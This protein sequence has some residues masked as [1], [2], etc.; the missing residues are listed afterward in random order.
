MS[1][2]LYRPTY[3]IHH[4]L[5][6]KQYTVQNSFHTPFLQWCAFC[7]KLTTVAKSI[8][9]RS[10]LLAVS[11]PTK[12]CG[13]RNGTSLAVKRDS[14]H[15]WASAWI[16]HHSIFALKPCCRGYAMTCE[17]ARCHF[18]DPLKACKEMIEENCGRGIFFRISIFALVLLGVF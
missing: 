1:F 13:R 14:T 10:G 15:L 8:H 7:W 3:C 11:S 5:K 6:I 9:A 2:G 17:E 4:I 12:F 18:H 16:T